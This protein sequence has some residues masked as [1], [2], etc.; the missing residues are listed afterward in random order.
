MRQGFETRTR[1]VPL[2]GSVMERGPSLV[3][4]MEASEPCDSTQQA[5]AASPWVAE[6]GMQIPQE[7]RH[8]T[9]LRAVSEASLPRSR[10]V[11]APLADFCFQRLSSG[12]LALTPTTSRRDRPG[13][14]INY[15]TTGDMSVISASDFPELQRQFSLRSELMHCP[16]P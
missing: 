10:S 14:S 2:P 5:G 12:R 1:S 9:P 7:L 11:A 3:S 15:S 13:F 8:E 6:R 16:K 4:V